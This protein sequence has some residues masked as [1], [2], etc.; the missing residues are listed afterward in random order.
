MAISLNQFGWSVDNFSLNH[1][2]DNP[3]NTAWSVHVKNAQSPTGGGKDASGNKVWVFFGKWNNPKFEK[4]DDGTEHISSN[5]II[6]K[7]ASHLSVQAFYLRMECN[8]E[9]AGKALK[10]I[11]LAKMASLVNH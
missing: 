4:N 8:D 5:A 2:I 6:N 7:T 10:M 11:D 1:R 9:L 3:D